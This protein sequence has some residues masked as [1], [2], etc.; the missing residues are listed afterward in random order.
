MYRPASDPE[1]SIAIVGGGFSGTTLAA[2]L[3]RTSGPSVSVVLIERGRC[4][5]RGVAYGTR[6]TRHLLNVRAQN[7]SAFQDDPG[8]FLHWAR[9][10][11]DSSTQ[12]G[13]F[14]PRRAYGEYIDSIFRR[15]VEQHA[16]RFQHIHSEAISMSYANGRADIFLSSG[17]QVAADIVVLALGN[18]PPG[19][20][21]LPGK[22]NPSPRYMANGWSESALDNV[23][24]DDSVLLIGSGLTS[25]DVVL[26][27]RERNCSGTIHMISRHGLLPQ[28][29]RLRAQWPAFWNRACPQTAR[30]LVRLVRE[31]VR[32][33]EKQNIDWRAILD[34]I[35]P[36]T[37]QIWQSLSLQEQ[38][39]FLRHVRSYWDVHRHRVAP[40]IG[41][42]LDSELRQGSLQVH[43]G[44]ITNYSERPGFVTIT[45]SDRES[46]QLKKLKVDRVIN[47]T[48]PEAD[49]RRVNDPL[50]TDLLRQQLVRPDALY[51][52]L[53]TCE[54][55]SL[56]DGR[57]VASDF[58]YTLGPLRKG[59]LWET[60]AVPEIREQVARLTA[61]LIAMIDPRS[62]GSVAEEA[63]IR[64]SGIGLARN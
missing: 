2:E 26:S 32:E 12:P 7:M 13:D 37:E 64:E 17:R 30:G 27:L 6:C 31:Q 57:G 14:L 41:G 42:V 20:L 60:I 38:R 49:C 16:D 50:L 35:R 21:N 47:C 28:H 8:H 34:S 3:L 58:L 43:G 39:R 59:N 22:R 45:Y 5:G 19:D 25:V 29:Q 1:V 63:S 9:L 4:M 46:Q 15:A 62:R 54:N 61:H 44:R 52:G 53:D 55:G 10:H 36:V 56:L 11:Y 33:A 40:E 51:L 23:A 18:F 24:P 48:G